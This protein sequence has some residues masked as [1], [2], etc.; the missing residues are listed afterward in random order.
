VQQTRD[1]LG[2]LQGQ[3]NPYF[4]QQSA[5][6][7]DIPSVYQGTAGLYGNMLNQAGGSLAQQQALLQNMGT[8]ES[9]IASTRP[10]IQD[11]MTSMG[12]RGLE[13]SSLA[14]R[15]VANTLGSLWAQ[16]QLGLANAYQ[17]LAGQQQTLYGGAA[18]GLQNLGGAYQGLAGQYGQLGMNQAN[19]LGNLVNSWQNLISGV[20]NLGSYWYHPYDVMMQHLAGGGGVS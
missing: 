15:T 7:G 5:L 11:I 12:R 10:Y 8:P 13:S 3:V 19:I 20:G 18:Q 1:I 14:D 4:A 9:F 6:L 16:N 17:G 2:G